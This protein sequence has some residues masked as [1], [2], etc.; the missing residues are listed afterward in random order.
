[1]E[2]RRRVCRWC[3]EARGYFSAESARVIYVFITTP[4]IMQVRSTIQPYGGWCVHLQWP[5]AKGS[6]R[7]SWMMCSNFRWGFLAASKDPRIEG[8]PRGAG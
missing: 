5:K 2:E 3:N 1:M 8:V 4:L 6:A 7:A